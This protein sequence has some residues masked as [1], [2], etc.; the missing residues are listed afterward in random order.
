MI[1]TK[2][3]I[4][5]RLAR[6]NQEI[7]GGRL[8]D[9]PVRMS[10]AT[11]FLGMC[12]AKVRTLP[13]ARR[14]HFD[15]ELRISTRHDIPEH[16]L[17]DV[18]IHEMIHYFI[19]YNGLADTA[20]HGE[21]FK[22]MMKSINRMHG[23]GIT[24]SRRLTADE[25]AKVSDGK[26]AWHVIAAIRFHDGRTGLKVLPRVMPKILDYHRHVLLSPEV[27]TI[28]LYLHDD[29]FFNRYPVSAAY[30]VHEIEERILMEHLKGAHRLEVRGNKIVQC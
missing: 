4:E 19:M 3:F 11:S 10:D 6:F 8:P 14:E 22:G 27:R 13:G 9:I 30:R 29:P 20:P 26:R 15:F 1:A 12:V 2:K 28:S 21:I 16:E 7:F 25:K 24:V 23:R 17:E 18:V 5:D